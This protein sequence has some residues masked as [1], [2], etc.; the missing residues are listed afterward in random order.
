M[1]L[2]PAQPEEASALVAVVKLELVRELA[3]LDAVNQAD[4]QR[5]EVALEADADARPRSCS[6]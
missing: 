3:A 4:A 2:Q 1:E 5:A 6:Q